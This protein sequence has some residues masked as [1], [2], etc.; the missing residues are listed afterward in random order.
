M[1]ISDWSSDVCSSDLHAFDGE[2]GQAEG[3]GDILDL[4]AFLDQADKA[5]P[6]RHFIG[7]EPRHVLDQRGFDGIGIVA[8]FE[9]RAWQWS[10]VDALGQSDAIGGPATRPC[11]DLE[12]AGSAIG[13][14]DQRLRSEEHTSE[15]QSLMRISYA[16]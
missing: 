4:A 12:R 1:R 5:F 13:A 10:V 14:H 9:D 7:V 11:D 15:L 2:V 6:L 3:R 8:R 16:V